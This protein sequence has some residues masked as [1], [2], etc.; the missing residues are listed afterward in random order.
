[1]FAQTQTPQKRPAYAQK[2]PWKASSELYSLVKRYANITPWDTHR[3]HLAQIVAEYWLKSRV[4]IEEETLEKLVASGIGLPLRYDD[5]HVEPEPAVLKAIVNWFHD[6]HLSVSGYYAKELKQKKP[7]IFGIEFDQ[8]VGISILELRGKT[9]ED[10]PLFNEAN[11]SFLTLSSYKFEASILE[12]KLFFSQYLTR[13][14]TETMV[15]LNKFS[16]E[17]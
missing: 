17:K 4:D 3:D 13:S 14:D 12:R 5:G 15:S 6:H 9:L 7:Q 2:L 8:I 11:I 16:F 10:I 1:V